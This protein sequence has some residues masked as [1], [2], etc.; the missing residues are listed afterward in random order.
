MILWP[1]RPTEAHEWK[2]ALKHRTQAGMAKDTGLENVSMEDTFSSLFL[3]HSSNSPS[4]IIIPNLSNPDTDIESV[5]SPLS[6]ISIAD[7]RGR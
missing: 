1:G 6:T 5:I 7:L 4:P 3:I 2:P